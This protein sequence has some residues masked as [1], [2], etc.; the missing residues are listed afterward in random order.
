MT[1]DKRELRYFSG[2]YPFELLS[3]NPE[4]YPYAKDI[5]PRKPGMKKYSKW[6]FKALL[7]SSIFKRPGWKIDDIVLL[8][9]GLMF[10]HV[11]P[12]YKESKNLHHVTKALLVYVRR[13]QEGER[14]GN[15]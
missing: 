12:R 10:K 8:P 9:A 5:Y 6:V 7:N 13:I 11:S 4:D 3:K 15:K 1:E 14:Y 2:L